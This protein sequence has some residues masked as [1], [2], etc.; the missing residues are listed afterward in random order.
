MRKYRTGDLPD[1]QILVSD[2]MRPILALGEYS[3]NIAS[4]LC[5]DIIQVILYLV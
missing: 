4:V 5:A 1:I 2:L 3:V